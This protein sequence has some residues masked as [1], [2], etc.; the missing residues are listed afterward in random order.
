MADSLT[1]EIIGAAI[2]VHKHL[3]PGL[4][5][6]IYEECLCHELEL[7]GIPYERQKPIE[8]CYKDLRAA[9]DFRIDL[10][11]DN[12]VVVELKA[13]KEF[14]PIYQAQLLTYM[15]LS[16]C[17]KGLIIN[18]NVPLLKDGLKRMIL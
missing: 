7:R 11:V 16:G 13:V 4:L 17:K 9:F 3:G 14:H 10:I 18:F 8:I 6:S 15:K 1:K 5:E 2:E 12:S